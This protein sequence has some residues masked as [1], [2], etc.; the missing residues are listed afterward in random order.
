M[1]TL[2]SALWVFKSVKYTGFTFCHRNNT[3]LPKLHLIK[4][5]L[6]CTKHSGLRQTG[7]KGGNW[8]SVKTSW[9]EWTYERLWEL[10]KDAAFS[11]TAVAFFHFT[12]TCPHTLL[13]LLPLLTSAICSFSS[14]SFEFRSQFLEGSVRLVRSICPVIQKHKIR[15]IARKPQDISSGYRAL[16]CMTVT[17]L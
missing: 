6:P 7:E 16:K 2:H 13:T 17:L 10:A 1:T 14:F 4:R 11:C 15:R 12:D 3:C 5:I 8:G 9:K